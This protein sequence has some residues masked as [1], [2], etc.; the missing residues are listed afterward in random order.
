[1]TRYKMFLHTLFQSHYVYK[2]ISMLRAL[3]LVCPLCKSF[4]CISKESTKY[5]AYNFLICNYVF[6][7]YII[8]IIYIILY[9][10]C[11]LCILQYIYRDV[12]R[13]EMD[14]CGCAACTTTRRKI[15]YICTQSLNLTKSSC[16]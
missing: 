9:I 8:Y 3:P 12:P 6:N 16:A 4:I 10:L 5:T 14:L 2:F 11:I 13:D 7:E 1:M 15:Y